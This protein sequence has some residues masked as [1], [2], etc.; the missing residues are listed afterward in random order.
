VARRIVDGAA[1]QRFV[2]TG[3]IRS[4][5]TV[6]IGPSLAYACVITDGTGELALIFVGRNSIP[7]VV[8]GAL[9]TVEGT[10]RMVG[11]RL[12]LWNPRYRVGPRRR[13]IAEETRLK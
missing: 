2:V 10:A 3:E 13:R 9:C 8:P 6:K 12:E 7:G 1:R 11:E 4:A 5:R